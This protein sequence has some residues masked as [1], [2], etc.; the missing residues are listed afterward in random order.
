VAVGI[1]AADRLVKQA[2]VALLKAGTV[3]RGRYLILVGGTVASVEEAHREAVATAGDWLSD[4]VLL[5]DA[6]PELAATVFGAD[7]PPTREALGIVET[8]SVPCLLRGADAALKSTTVRLARLRLADGLGG[9]AYLLLDGEIAEVDAACEIACA[10]IPA[11]RLLA[12]RVLPRLDE[13]TRALLA[14]GDRFAAGAVLEPE[15]ADVV[16]AGG[17]ERP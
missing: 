4:E 1:A 6:H 13:T 7:R 8:R 2:P 15:G 3:S 16:R 17:E 10:R 11:E 12:C 9:K 14:G 5:A